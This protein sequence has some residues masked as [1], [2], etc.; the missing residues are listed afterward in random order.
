[1][2]ST[3][4]HLNYSHSLAR[5]AHIPHGLCHWNPI[6]GDWIALILRLLL[7]IIIVLSLRLL[8]THFAWQKNS[9]FEAS[10]P[11]RPRTALL[12]LAEVAEF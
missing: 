6:A 8:R 11:T 10:D 9:F 12:L 5:P 1:M 2:K 3:T 4:L 7:R